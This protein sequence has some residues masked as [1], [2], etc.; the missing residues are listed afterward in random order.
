MF[1]LVVETSSRDCIMRVATDVQ[2][3]IDM[4]AKRAKRKAQKA[5]RR[6]NR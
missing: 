1:C 3:R 5:A 6:K 2:R 4:D